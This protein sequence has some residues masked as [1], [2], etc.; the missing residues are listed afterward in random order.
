MV[1][2]DVDHTI[3]RHSTGRRFGQQGA[4]MGLF[5]PL[6][7]LRAPFFYL[8]YKMGL[9]DAQDLSGYLAPLKGMSR[10]DVERVGR[11]CF[12]ERVKHE[13]YLDAQARI[14]NLIQH[15][16]KVALVSAS[17]DAV[18]HP[19]ADYLGVPDVVCTRIEFDGDRAT[20]GSSNPV[21]FG[22]EKRRQALA[23]L[24]AQGVSPT[25]CTF[26]SD[27]INDLPLLEAVGTPIAVNPDRRLR[28]IATE[29]GWT[30]LSFS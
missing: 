1:L 4:A 5:S 30:L 14:R 23:F 2:F 12:D 3:T 8:R 21:C 24:E 25:A 17:V 19:L 13:I 7:L 9:V 11:R 20:G 27:S 6:Y 16:E 28:R 26:Y 10:Q 15:G 22:D 29:R 18:V